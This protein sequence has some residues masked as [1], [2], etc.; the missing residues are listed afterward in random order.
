[1]GP[2]EQFNQVLKNLEQVAATDL[3]VILTGETGV[4]KEMLAQRLHQLSSRKNGPFV[5]LNCAAL[6]PNLLESELFGHV[7]GAYTGAGMAKAGYLASAQGGTLFL[8]EIGESSREFQVR[9][10]RVL[11]DKVITPVGSAKG[12]KI[13]FRIVCATHLDLMEEVKKGRFH[14]GL[15]HRIMVVPLYLPPLR[16]RPQDLPCLID[17]F[18]EQ[19]CF[20]IKRTRRLHQGT[21]QKLLNY[22]WPG[23]VRQLKH[24]L[25]RLVALSPDFE[26]TE[27]YLPAEINRPASEDLAELINQNCKVPKNRVRGICR[28]LHEKGSSLFSN[29]DMRREL[30]CSDAT[31]KNILRALADAGIVEVTGKQGGR[32]YR[33]ISKLT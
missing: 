21:R 4:G 16:Q 19:A 6:S 14:K 10:L 30:D 18:M 5:P 32:R 17:H 24:V 7:K 33:L 13:D 23:N 20:L 1:V 26:I 22:S 15:L 2:S 25:Q 28:V 11:E 27:N 9:L 29:Q 31:A 12:R 8:D 3:P